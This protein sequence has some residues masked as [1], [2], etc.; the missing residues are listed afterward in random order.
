MFDESFD[1]EKSLK[2]KQERGID[3]IEAR[4]V[5]NDPEAIEGLAN[6]VMGENRWLKVGMALGKIW[7]VCFTN[8][9]EGIRII[10]VRPARDD[11][12]EAYGA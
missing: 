11:E 8:R 7:T 5:W 2:T 12:K 1:K 4:E 9:P 6:V 3:F 10:S